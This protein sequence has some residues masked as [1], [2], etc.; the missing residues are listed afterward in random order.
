M[1]IREISVPKYD[2]GLFPTELKEINL[3]SNENPYV[4]INVLKSIRKKLKDINRYP[5]PSYRDLK[6]ALSTYLD[7]PEDNITL[8]NGASEAFYYLS[9]IIIEPF[10]KVTIPVPTYSLYFI[11]IILRDAYPS[12]KYTKL[13]KFKHDEVIEKDSKAIFL[14]SPNNPTGNVIEKKTFEKILEEF[15]GFIILDE[16]YVEFY[17]KSFLDY[18]TDYKNLIIVRSMSKFFSLAGLRIGYVIADR[19]IID[20]IER[21]KCPFNI[22]ILAYYAAI[23][24]LKNLDFFKKVREVIIRERE[25]LYRNLKRIKFLN[26]YKSH[27]N[28][29]LVESYYPRLDEKLVNR[30]ILIRNVSNVIGLKGNFFRITVGKRSENNKLVRELKCLEEIY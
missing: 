2:A 19:K 11:P 25:R 29:L 28:F 6:K 21:I 24:A 7:I 16:A 22:N 12:I 3:S 30:G 27:A 15:N 5:N 18:V 23:E 8:T 9:E 4:C 20:L 1:K 17:G 14:C 13:Y 10:D 26:P